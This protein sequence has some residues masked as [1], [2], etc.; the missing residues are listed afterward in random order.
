MIAYSGQI[1]PHSG[2]VDEFDDFGEFITL[3]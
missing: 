1:A 2:E 3:V